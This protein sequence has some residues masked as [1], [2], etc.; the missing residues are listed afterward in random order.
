MFTAPTFVIRTKMV[1]KKDF[2]VDVEPKLTHK[3]LIVTS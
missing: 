1:K 3:I 2:Y